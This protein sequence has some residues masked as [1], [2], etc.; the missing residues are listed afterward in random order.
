M[1]ASIVASAAPVPI[2]M[3]GKT[4]RMSSLTDGAIAE[5]TQWRRKRE[6]QIASDTMPS[7]ISEERW[8]AIHNSAVARASELSF[9]DPHDIKIWSTI[10]GLTVIYWH[11]LRLNHPDLT[12]E[13]TASMLL[14]AE[15]L[16]EINLGF[17]VLE[18][19]KKKASTVPKK[20]SE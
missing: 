1:S 11:M 7:D 19:A 4:W 9:P 2:V 5:I 20:K 13:A 3:D 18:L 8:L 10:E 17:S 14:T 6:V 12:L 15:N 16:D